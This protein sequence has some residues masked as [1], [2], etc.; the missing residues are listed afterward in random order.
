MNSNSATSAINITV[1][2]DID[3]NNNYTTTQLS[4]F[5]ELQVSMVEFTVHVSY[6]TTF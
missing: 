6:F 1:A 2:D 4:V 5:R 3:Y